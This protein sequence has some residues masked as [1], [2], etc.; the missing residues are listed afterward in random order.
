MFINRFLRWFGAIIVYPFVSLLILGGLTIS[1]FV[2]TV[3]ICF[4]LYFVYR[5]INVGR[6]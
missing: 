5:C 3:A 1:N 4:V 2:V 6:L